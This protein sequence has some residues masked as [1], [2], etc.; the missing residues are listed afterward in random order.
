MWIK[1]YKF[2]NLEEEA[3]NYSKGKEQLFVEELTR[4]CEELDTFIVKHLAPCPERNHVMQ[5]VREVFLW[6]RY[7]SEL[8]G[9]K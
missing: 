7:C 1:G 2:V 3:L 8:N 4:Q 5:S 9:V 6:A